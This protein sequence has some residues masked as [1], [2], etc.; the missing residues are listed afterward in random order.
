ERFY[1]HMGRGDE[2][3]SA[4]RSTGRATLVFQDILAVIP[5]YWVDAHYGG[6]ATT[7]Y[8]YA[9]FTC[10]ARVIEE[11]AEVVSVLQGLM[12]RF[13]PEKGYEPLSAGSE[14]YR[15]SVE[16]LAI[17]ELKVL[18]VD[19]KWKL[20]QNRP[21]AVRLEVAKRLRE[22]GEGHDARAADEIERWIAN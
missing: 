8:R 17:A 21:E 10:A 16:S 9:A 12:D 22:R 6:A 1:L 7:Y 5:S 15:K 2:Q 14:R 3:V 13:Q 20:G 4:L 18:S 19:A 11:P